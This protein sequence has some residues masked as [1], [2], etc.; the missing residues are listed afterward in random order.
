MGVEL[1]SKFMLIRGRH[2]QCNTTN[3]VSQAAI[4]SCEGT[5]VSYALNLYIVTPNLVKP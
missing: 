2:Y 3:S 1:D 5:M 4:A